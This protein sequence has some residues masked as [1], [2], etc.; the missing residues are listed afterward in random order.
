[1]KTRILV[2]SAVLCASLV[3]TAAAAGRGNGNGNA[4]RGAGR[5]PACDLSRPGQGVPLRDGSGRVQA[6]RG[7]PASNGTPRRDGSGKATAPGKGAKDGTG[8]RANC[9]MPT[10]GG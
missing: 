10:P 8:N 7:N 3:A 4:N 2:L 1:M 5:P 9:P 6:G